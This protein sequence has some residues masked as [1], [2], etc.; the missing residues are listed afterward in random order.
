MPLRAARRERK[1]TQQGAFAQLDADLEDYFSQ[2]NRPEEMKYSDEIAG[3]TMNNG[4][5]AAKAS[6]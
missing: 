2:R 6:P 5:P 4:Q 3:R 1:D